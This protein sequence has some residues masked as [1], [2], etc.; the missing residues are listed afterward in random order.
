MRIIAGYPA[1][2]MAEK[3]REEPAGSETGAGGYP[4]AGAA[5]ARAHRRIL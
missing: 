2:A 5:A 4:G 3:T 1:P